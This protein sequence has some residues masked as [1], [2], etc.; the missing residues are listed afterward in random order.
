MLLPSLRSRPQV[1]EKHILT[2]LTDVLS[3]VIVSSYSD[4]DLYR[5]AT[6]TPQ[7]SNR[8]LEAR[9]LREAL[10][11]SLRDLR[12]QLHFCTPPVVVFCPTGFSTSLYANAGAIPCSNGVEFGAL[13]LMANN[14]RRPAL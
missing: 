12:H 7:V 4:E 8:R 9:Q 10:E 6:E 13:Y 14:G 1:V 2:K 5:L 3:S 11:E